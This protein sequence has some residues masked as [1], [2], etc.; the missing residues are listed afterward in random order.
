[1]ALILILNI[2][3][4][5][6]RD[7]LV[8]HR[9][10]NLLYLECDAGLNRAMLIGSFAPLS[11]LFRSVH[12]QYVRYVPLFL[13]HSKVPLEY[14]RNVQFSSYWIAAHVLGKVRGLLEL[15]SESLSQCECP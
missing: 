4:C 5:Q 8:H 10:Q 3:N 9:S 1:V 13:Y 11:T 2:G 12:H 7:N 14:M 6:P 15:I